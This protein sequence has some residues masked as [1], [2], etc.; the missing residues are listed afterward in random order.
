M[1]KFATVAVFS[2]AALQF[3]GAAWFT[4]QAAF[5]S[6]IR[7]DY[8]HEAFSNFTYGSPLNGSQTSW[9][10]PG[11]NGYDWKATNSVGL[12]SNLHAIST[13]SA[14]GVIKITFT[15][16]PVSAFGGWLGSSDFFGNLQPGTETITLSDGR[17][18]SIATGAGISFL[19]YVGNRPFSYVNLSVANLGGNDWIQL[20]DAYVGRSRREL[21]FMQTEYGGQGGIG[22]S[23]PEPG[24]LAVLGVGALAM[25]VRRR[26]R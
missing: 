2:L 22:S 23:T 21:Q 26:R 19:G 24:M 25:L 4:D 8:Y 20:S 14:E 11:A 6:A 1:P 13:D 7:S 9:D 15:G 17:S 5:L 16:Q 12:Y 10:A 3:A 18:H